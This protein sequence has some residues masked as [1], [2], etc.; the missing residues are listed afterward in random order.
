[1]SVTICRCG[2]S[3]R[4]A[5]RPLNSTYEWNILKE[6]LIFKKKLQ[7]GPTVIFN[8]FMNSSDACTDE[9]VKCAN[10]I[11]LM[12]EFRLISKLKNKI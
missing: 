3:S 12:G 1:M 5:V 11:D 9:L 4:G 10:K 7:T 6:H 8:I 2:S